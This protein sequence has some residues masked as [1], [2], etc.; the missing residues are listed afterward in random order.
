MQTIL[1]VLPALD[2]GGVELSVLEQSAAIANEGW[3]SL[4]ASQ[5]GRLVS[6]LEENGIIHIPLP[7]V[8]KKPNFYLC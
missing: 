6:K 3:N 1:H 8:F 2:T 7:L 5:G 4:V